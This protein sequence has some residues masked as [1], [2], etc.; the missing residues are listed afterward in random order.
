VELLKICHS[1]YGC[2]TWS[3]ARGEVSRKRLLRLVERGLLVRVRPQVYVVAGIQ[4]VWHVRAKALELSI[5]GSALSHLSAARA[6]GLVESDGVFLHLTTPGS[7]AK[8]R[9]GARVHRSQQLEGFRVA[10]EGLTVTTV[11]RTLVNLSGMISEQRLGKLIDK[12]FN[13]SLVTLEQ[14]RETRNAMECKGL[15][16]VTRFDR[17]LALRN[18]T[19]EALE[20]NLE[21][22]VL[23]WIRS[24][25]LPEPEAQRYVVAN[26]QRYQPDLSYP[27]WKIAIEPDGNVHLTP[28]VAARDRRK[29]ADMG[30][31][32][33]IV[34]HAGENDDR[35]EVIQRIRTAIERR[36]T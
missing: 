30:I 6:W 34:I 10:R 15:A 26:G 28:S 9:S 2:V 4:P 11:A 8:V 35:W 17:Q 27:E 13:K 22:K 21:R 12:A 32:G 5:P 18:E 31:D 23:G 29:N 14:L 7:R 24:A 20:T 25:E 1:Q 16:A 33:W 3:Q 36:R 19:D